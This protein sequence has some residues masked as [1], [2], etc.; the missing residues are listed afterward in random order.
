MI[1]RVLIYDPVPFKGGSKI[2]M[3]TIVAE[4]PSYIEVWVISNDSDSWCNFNVHFVPLF[5]PLYL[6]NK[7]T[8]MLYFL[9]HFVYLF[10][11]ITKMMKLKRFSKI[12]GFSGPN[13]DFSLYLLTEIINIDIIQLIQG[14]IANSKVAS[15]GLTRAKQVFYL[16]STYASIFHALK[17]HSNKEN[18]AN[19][20]YIPFVNGINCSTIKVKDT[21]NKSSDKIG[22]L[23]AASLLKWK[24]IELFIAAITKLNSSYEDVNKYFASVC[25]IEPKNDSYLD[26]A[27]FAKVDNIHWYA[28]PNNL[29]E[30]RANSSV[31]ISTAEHEP[32]G[33]SILESMAAGLAI[34]IPADNAY[35]DQQLTNNYDCLKYSP[36]NMESLVQV[37]TRLINDPTL[38]LNIAQQAKLRVQHYSHRSC[39]AHILKSIRN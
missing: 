37:L 35:W 27:D 12:I 11:L 17:C 23:W 28:D 7:T 22:F 25:Y 5:S 38:L 26:I 30:I 33:L 6:Q 10:S 16:P 39:Y 18:I 2:V 34:V 4:L 32:F 13:V 19:N 8:G 21:N 3:K 24:H 14:D 31:F 15:F 29:N 36:N 1:K 9:K 20:K